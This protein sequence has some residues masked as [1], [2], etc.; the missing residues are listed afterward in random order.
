MYALYIYLDDTG[1][2]ESI[3]CDPTKHGDLSN[4]II[5]I[6]QKRVSHH[7]MNTSSSAVMQMQIKLE[8]MR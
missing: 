5:V 8:Q 4:N 3:F 1:S 2:S 6:L 7:Q